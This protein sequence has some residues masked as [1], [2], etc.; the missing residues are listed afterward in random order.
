MI[1]PQIEESWKKELWDEFQKP[2]FSEIK[3]FLQKEKSEGKT[4]YPEGKNIFNAYN[5]T[6]FDKV[7]VVLL[8]QDPYHQPGQAH[9][10]CF[11]VKP[12][13]KF[14]PSLQNIFKELET[15]IGIKI[16][17]NGYLQKRAEQGVFML[18]ASLTVRRGEPMSHSQIGREKFTDATIKTLS[19]KRNG[20]I[21]VLRG[22]FAGSKKTL[23]DTNRH[24]VLEAPHPSPLSS[25]RGFFGCKHFSKIN[26]ILKSNGKKEIDWQIE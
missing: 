23:I 22:S 15:D 10:L 1:N 26:E 3:N 5:S 24:Y 8:G 20:L 2:Y 14:P 6:P 11:S 25:H 9:G 18:N 19:D 7:K 4:I 13:V 12:G 17:T 16:P 21:F